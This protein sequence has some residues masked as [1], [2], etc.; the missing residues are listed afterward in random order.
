[1][2][3][4][5]RIDSIRAE[6]LG[7]SEYMTSRPSYAAVNYET[8]HLASS[9]AR[10]T[11]RRRP[12]QATPRHPSPPT[13]GARQGTPCS[14]VRMG[15]ARRTPPARRQGFHRTRASSTPACPMIDHRAPAPP[16]NPDVSTLLCVSRFPLHHATRPATPRRA[17]AYVGTLPV[18]RLSRFFAPRCLWTTMV[19]VSP[20][21]GT[22]SA[23]RPQNT[24]GYPHPGEARGDERIRCRVA[25]T[26]DRHDPRPIDWCR[27]SWPLG[28]GTSTVPTDG[29]DRPTG[30][31]RRLEPRHLDAAS[32]C[33]CLQALEWRPHSAA[34]GDRWPV[35]SACPHRPAPAPAD[36]RGTPSHH[37]CLRRQAGPFHVKRALSP[38]SGPRVNGRDR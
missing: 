31:H 34:S 9:R 20:V 38:R 30:L 32:T 10:N 24:R 6:R 36:A 7:S 26:D 8:E 17:G 5:I 33:S 27:F 11:R 21:H 35:A 37:K 29:L 1:M 14:P 4:C 3:S 28:R 22:F 19:G 13:T 15:E 23:V 25:G 2:R 18:V 12:S 16:L